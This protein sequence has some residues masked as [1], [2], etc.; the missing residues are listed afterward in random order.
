M[1]VYFKVTTIKTKGMAKASYTI[2][3]ES[4]IIGG[5][6]GMELIKS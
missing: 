1:E 4:F 6:G 2:Q 3:K 5:N